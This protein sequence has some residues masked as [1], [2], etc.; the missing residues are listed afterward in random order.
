M[1][2]QQRK[3]IVWTVFAILVALILIKI[4]NISYP[5]SVTTATK[6]SELA[7]TGEGKV[8]VV[9]DTAYIDLGIT[10]DNAPTVDI[11][12]GDINEVNSRI[13]RVLTALGIKKENIK[14]SNYSI[15]PNYS[16]LDDTVSQ[17]RNYSGNTTVTIKLEQ[18]EL[19]EKALDASIQAGANQVQGVRFEVDKPETFREKARNKA[20]AN[21]QEQAK[22]ISKSLKLRLGRVVNIVETTPQ[23][24]I[25]FESRTLQ[26]FGGTDVAS[27]DIEAGTQT[28]TSVVTLYFEKK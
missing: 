21:A 2:D 19:V 10:V 28:I 20:I 7:V 11:A 22:K 8:E 15:Y 26:G 9:P 14:T 4:F 25:P 3:N 1:E 27:T 16:Q 6:S 13:I 12:Q 24:P 17:I 5:I 18:T 23:Q